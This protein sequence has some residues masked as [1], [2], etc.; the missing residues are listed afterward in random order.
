MAAS[1]DLIAQMEKMKGWI[2]TFAADVAAIEALLAEEKAED[3]ARLHAAAALNYLVTRLDLIPDWE[4]TCGILDDAMI[5]RLEMA[6]AVG[7]DLG[8]LSGD[9]LHAVG[10]LANEADLV[11]EFLGSDL[12]PRLRKYADGLTQVV[13]R[14][15]SPRA[16]VDD[17]KERRLLSVE[18]QDELKRLPPAPMSDPQRIARVIKNYLTQKLK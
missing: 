7:Q 15:R 1:P 13:V 10:R 5:L 8:D 12:Y 18:I 17:A 4:E 11:K 6:V 9:A 16:L 14:G 3:D 2:D